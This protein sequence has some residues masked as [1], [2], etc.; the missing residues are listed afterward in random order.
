MT[1]SPIQ[2]PQ[3]QGT[4]DRL[5]PD[6]R[7][8]IATLPAG[9]DEPD[10]LPV[11]DRTGQPRR[12]PVMV[13]ADAFLYL[14]CAI[15]AVALALFWWQAITITRFST[16]ARLMT[17]LAP[18]PGSWQSMLYS[19]LVF[20]MALVTI[21]TAAL[22]A[23]QAWNGYAWSRIAGL[24]ALVGAALTI[25]QN[26]VAML[27]IVPI[28]IGVV[29]LWLPT[30]RPYFDQWA[31]FRAGPAPAPD[32]VESVWYGPAPRYGLTTNTAPSTTGGR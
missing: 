5:G 10:Q 8:F 25:A 12:H 11:S 28:V 30:L 23:F 18:R 17:W 20:A 13:V 7:G 14:G 31:R 32:L 15:T 4:D 9:A 16:S 3:Q 19:G 24:V 6:G 26:Q 29:L 21:T 1:H 27:A 22:A 2:A